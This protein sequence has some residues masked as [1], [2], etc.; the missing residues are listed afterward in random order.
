MPG[1]SRIKFP[2]IEEPSLR[3]KTMRYFMTIFCFLFLV[4]GLAI[5]TCAALLTSQR[6]K[7]CPFIGR[8]YSG[9]Y[10]LLAAGCATAV[11]S[12]VGCVRTQR[13]ASPQD[14]V[15]LAVVALAVLVLQVLAAVASHVLHT[16]AAGGALGAELGGRVEGYY[17][18][19]RRCVDALQT[20][21]RCCGVRNYTEWPPLSRG[22]G[23]ALPYPSS[24]RCAAG[25]AL[26]VMVTN[27]SGN[28]TLG[29]ATLTSH[30]HSTPCHDEVL[31]DLLN[32]LLV[33]RI[34][35]PLASVVELAVMLAVIY[36][37]HHIDNRSLVGAYVVRAAGEATP[38]G[39]DTSCSQWAELQLS[40]P[41]TC[42]RLWRQDPSSLSHDET[43]MHL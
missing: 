3:V 39:R 24:C 43:S 22:A 37:L 15:A 19:D 16:S 21:F 32:T 23:S 42:S 4:L 18:G 12:L 6:L 25:G 9:V 41:S 7:E 31:D 11:F 30:V 14:F 29:N 17:S 34:V 40:R 20:H 8:F 10:L 35:G 5:I 26:C 38:A 33:P 1:M 13:S 2:H 28:A 36:F 27:R